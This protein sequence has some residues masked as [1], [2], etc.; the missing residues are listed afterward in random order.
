[1]KKQI[2][3]SIAALLLLTS[4]SI[5]ADASG[6]KITSSAFQNNGMIPAK[7]TCDVA[8]SNP[9]LRIENV[10]AGT[11]SL[12]L[13][14]DDP[15][16]AH[17][18]WVHWV[19]WNIDPKTTE[20]RKNSVPQGAKQG[21]NDHRKNGYNGPCPPTG[22]HRYFFKLY[23]LDTVLPLDTDSRKSDLEKAMKGHIIGEAQ[24]MGRYRRK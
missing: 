10:P 15:D 22:T 20:I 24:L 4:V 17:G 8:D 12:A 6:L 13:I 9:P 23:A 2:I 1:M 5:A 11:K 18:V 3:F 14:V 7:Y 21:I 16:T 19:M